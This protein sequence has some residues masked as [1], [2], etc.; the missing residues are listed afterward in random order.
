MLG[1]NGFKIHQKK[2]CWKLMARLLKPET[3]V[4]HNKP[5]SLSAAA[6]FCTD[7]NSLYTTH[8]I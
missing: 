4:Y 2:T 7:V 1:Q 8:V 3:P 5:E 6:L